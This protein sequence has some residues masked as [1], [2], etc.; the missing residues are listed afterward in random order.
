M[1]LEQRRVM[2]H[3]LGN[4]RRG[5][6]PWT[7][8]AQVSMRLASLENET[9]LALERAGFAFRGVSFGYFTAFHVTAKGIAALGLQ[10]LPS[11]VQV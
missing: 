1:T 3:A 5:E 4:P 9:W 6:R 10:C 8:V 11:E 7:N 2:L